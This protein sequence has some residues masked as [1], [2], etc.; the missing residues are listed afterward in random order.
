MLPLQWDH[1]NLAHIARH[2]ITPAEVEEVLSREL[3][4][5]GHNEEGGEIR[6]SYVGITLHG[7]I[8][9]VIVTERMNQL[10]PVTAYEPGASLRRQ[11][12]QSRRQH[13]DD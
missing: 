4:D 6:F 13:E 9:L 7:R 8:L 11:F 5:L 1:A 10:R 2:G 3:F 12:L